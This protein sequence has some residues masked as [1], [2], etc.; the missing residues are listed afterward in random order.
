VRLQK[1]LD[2]SATSYAFQGFKRLTAQMTGYE[3][4]LILAGLFFGVAINEDTA[5]VSGALLSCHHVLPAWQPFLACFLGM[6]SSDFAI[7]AICSFG[8]PYVLRNGF[9]RRLVAPEKVDIASRWFERYGGFAVVFSRFILG[10][11]TALLVVSGLMKYPALRFLVVTFLGG[12]GWLLL[13]Y[14]LFAILGTGATVLFGMR[15]IAALVMVFF[16]GAATAVIATRSR[17]VRA[18]RH[19]QQRDT[20]DT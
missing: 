6:W 5:V 16:G 9:V 15:W 19:F 12:I 4:D 2:S 13:V 17:R 8:G 10:T 1:K 11:R 20:A 3:K 14:L 18:Q 7:Y